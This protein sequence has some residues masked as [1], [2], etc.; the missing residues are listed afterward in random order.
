MIVLDSWQVWMLLVCLPDIAGSQFLNGI[1]DQHA[2]V[3]A[4]RV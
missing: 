4:V 2:H 1:H 3:C